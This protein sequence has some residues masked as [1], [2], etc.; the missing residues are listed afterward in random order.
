MGTRE[1][2]LTQTVVPSVAA[3]GGLHM[4]VLHPT[5][6]THATD[7]RRRRVS[8]R[9][10]ALRHHR[11][12]QI[13]MRS[14]RAHNREGTFSDVFGPPEITAGFGPRR[15]LQFCRSVSSGLAGQDGADP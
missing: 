15:A 1:N 8:H 3:S 12:D 11:T 2:K 7:A 9:A 5:C 14:R 10:P 6:H 4:S 13:A